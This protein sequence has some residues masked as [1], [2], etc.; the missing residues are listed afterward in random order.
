MPRVEV[1][2]RK[3]LPAI[4]FFHGLLALASVSIAQ[5]PQDNAATYYSRDKNFLI[6]FKSP[7]VASKISKIMLHVSEDFGKTYALAGTA[8]PSQ[9]QFLFRSPKDGWYWF[10]V[11]SQEVDGKMSP[12]NINLAPPSLKIC[13]DSTP[14]QVTLRGIL[15]DG[16]A[17]VDWDIRDENLDL[18]TMR[19][20]FRGADGKEWVPLSAQQ[21]AQGQHTWNPSG[22]SSIEVHLTIRDKA[23]NFGESKIAIQPNGMRSGSIALDGTG[24]KGNVSMVKSRRFQL[25]YKID[26]VGP[27]DVS[28]IEVYVTRDGGRT[29]RKYDQDAPKNPPCTIEVPEEGRYGFTLIARS[30]VDLGEQPPRS[31]DIPHFWVEVD[32]T[33]PVVRL[34]GVDV[35]RGIDL[36]NLSITWT[37]SD[38]YLGPNPIQISYAKTA[39]GPWTPAVSNLP[40]TG[41]YVWRLP[42]DGLPYQFFLRVEATDLA[43]N[44]GTAETTAPVKVDL[45]TP[46]ARVISA[47]VTAIGGASNTSAAPSTPVNNFTPPPPPSS[48]LPSGNNPPPFSPPPPPPPSS[49]SPEKSSANPASFPGSGNG[50]V[51]PFPSDPNKND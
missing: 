28:R 51:P 8:I 17:N 4:M 47:E 24:A 48:P 45:S 41:R 9:D 27:S 6:P 30:G 15:K 26:D 36:G 44:V 13:V 20:E 19:L 1:V 16:V 18:A 35:G 5:N 49:P 11:Q 12:P 38:R 25:N 43:G 46:K 21:L 31:G 23:G 40:N 39:E 50:S 33:R 3:F 37:A 10:A 7:G 22:S 42:N 29:W 34:I 2:I 14:P 32:E